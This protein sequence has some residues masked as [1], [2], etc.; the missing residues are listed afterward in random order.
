MRRLYYIRFI[1]F[2]SAMVVVAMYEPVVAQGGVGAIRNIGKI[3]QIKVKVSK[4]YPVR[5][6]NTGVRPIGPVITRS[7]VL[8]VTDT[9]SHHLKQMHVLPST[10]GVRRWPF[11]GL[12]SPSMGRIAIEGSFDTII[13]KRI[14][15]DARAV[16]I[17]VAAPPQAAAPMDG[18]DVE[19]PSL[20][21]GSCAQEED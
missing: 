5:G 7:R 18:A 16:G 13:P 17:P 12:L 11:D 20:H 21:Q 8:P 15:D 19:E 1:L 10:L 14:I 4:P 6:V 9:S 3:K 2:L